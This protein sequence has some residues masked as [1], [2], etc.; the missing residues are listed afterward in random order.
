MAKK[1][2]GK[3]TPKANVKVAA[4]ES[5]AIS[6][7][8]E[9][10][11]QK[12]K[13]LS[14]VPVALSGVS[15]STERPFLVERLLM[16][17]EVA[18]EYAV[19]QIE[20]DRQFDDARNALRRWLPTL[21]RSPMY[22]K[23][24]ITGV[25]VRYRTRFGRPV[26]PLQ[27]VVGVNVRTKRRPEELD[28]SEMLPTQIPKVPKKSGTVPVKVVE[29]NFQ[30]VAK[31]AAFLRASGTTPK[32]A[33]PFT[34]P[35]VG[36]AAI[37]PPQKPYEFGTIGVVFSKDG[38]EYLGMTCEHV[39]RQNSLVDQR[40]PDQGG[41]PD[42]R[43]LATVQLKKFGNT[44]HSETGRKETIDCSIVEI[45]VTTP[46]VP[47]VLPPPIGEY[48]I[49]GISYTDG[50]TPQAA[51]AIPLYFSNIP[52]RNA[53]VAFEM[54]KF[55]AAHGELVKGKLRDSDTALFNVG[56]VSFE[57][58][59]TVEQRDGNRFVTPGDSGSIIALR[60]K[61]N[62][63]PAFVAVGVLF[64]TL[65]D[66]GYIGLACNM[67]QVLDSLQPAI[68]SSRIISSWQLP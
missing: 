29:G 7:S 55:G 16:P 28:P 46:I 58:N 23:G 3:K 42:T 1:S 11:S 32:N 4:S 17:E 27:V 64:A 18:A 37:C 13:P 12:S 51:T 21:K 63:N 25:C 52:V 31:K 49:R 39:I 66:N 57:N 61:V 22:K 19:R 40:G 53:F 56:N 2:A 59:F 36:G 10:A 33:L 35:V 34:V 24:D 43:S 41:N 68:H 65:E 5:V 15:P 62:G 9:S 30:L 26:S 48:W 60:A 50:E 54:W 47:P 8:N 6:A 14:P 67:S 45:D 44:K 20:L 38:T